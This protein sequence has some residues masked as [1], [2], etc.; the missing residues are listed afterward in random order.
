[1][2]RTSGRLAGLLCMGGL[3]GLLAACGPSS[4]QTS[5]EAS[6]AD[7]A[8]MTAEM[9]LARGEPD[10]L[11]EGAETDA[12]DIADMQDAYAAD[13]EEEHLEAE[14]EHGEHFRGEAHVH[15]AAE[16]AVTQEDNF[17]TISV[18]APLA[19]FGLSE[20]TKKKDADF[21]QYAEGLTE[22]MGDARCDLVERS[23]AIRRSGDHAVLTLSIV[24]DC[25]RPSRLDGLMFTG[26]DLYPGFEKV[27]SVFL[28]DGKQTAATLTPASPFLPFSQ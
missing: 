7:M 17:I 14:E 6:S 26:F 2:N 23:A 8:P 3:I 1:M 15:G 19:N 5:E 24:W 28:G 20:G 12:S 9:P 27:S 18:D 11:A 25:R 10:S 13:A 21:E 16:L 4:K 22:L